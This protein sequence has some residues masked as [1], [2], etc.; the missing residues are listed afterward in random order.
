MIPSHSSASDHLYCALSLLIDAQVISTLTVSK[1]GNPEPQ[2]MY[3][4]LLFKSLDLL[5]VSD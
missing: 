4:L 2:F 1:T 3:V 5:T